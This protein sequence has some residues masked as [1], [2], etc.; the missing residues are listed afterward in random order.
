MATALVHQS[1]NLEFPARPDRALVTPSAAAR[2]GIQLPSVWVSGEERSPA[3]FRGSSP[4]L[5][6]PQPVSKRQAPAICRQHRC[7][8]RSRCY[9][10]IV[11]PEPP[12]SAGKSLSFGRPSFMGRTVDS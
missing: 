6:L 2:P 8:G 4:S 9:S 5:T 7:A 1:L 3:G 11:S 12:S 10:A